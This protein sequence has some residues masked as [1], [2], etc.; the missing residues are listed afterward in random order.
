M[1]A[2]IDRLQLLNRSLLNRLRPMALGHVP[3]QEILNEMVSERARQHPDISVSFSAAAL[4]PSYG[5]PIDLTVYRCLQ[6]S[7]TNAIRHAGGTRIE[8]ALREAEDG[9]RLTLTVKDDGRGIAPTASAGLG[10]TGMHERVQVLGGECTV[11]NV[12]G[13]GANVRVGIPLRAATPEERP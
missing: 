13:G 4:R 11:D 2:I 5:D 8:I 7:L 9:S 1:L 3:L 6:E 10:L 12:P